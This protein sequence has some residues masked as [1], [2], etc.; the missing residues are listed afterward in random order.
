MAGLWFRLLAGLRGNIMSVIRVPGYAGPGH[1]KACSVARPTT[2][3]AGAGWI[4]ATM[5]NVIVGFNE[6][7]RL[8]PRSGRTRS[9]GIVR[10]QSWL[11]LSLFCQ[12][13]LT[14]MTPRGVKR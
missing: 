9:I 2:I 14:R 10:I 5:G 8:S 12:T 11:L 6:T 1:V 7:P 4:G 13:Y 3:V